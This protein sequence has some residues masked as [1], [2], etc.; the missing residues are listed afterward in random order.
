MLS[1]YSYPFVTLRKR[2]YQRP[3]VNSHN[4]RTS[5]HQGCTFS[6]FFPSVCIQSIK[7]S[8]SKLQEEEIGEEGRRWGGNSVTL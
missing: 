8:H 6:S 7:F 1:Q 3:S 4:S 2:K 5:Q